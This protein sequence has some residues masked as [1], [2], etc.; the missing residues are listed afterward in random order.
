MAYLVPGDFCDLDVALL[1]EMDH[2]IGTLSPCEF[3]H[4]QPEVIQQLMHD[5]PAIG[6]AMRLAALVESAITREWVVNLGCRSAEERIAHLLLELLLRLQ[7]VGCAS[8]DSYAL[9]ITQPDIA[10]T[11]GLSLVHVSRTLK[12]LR[13][14][15]LINFAGRHVHILNFSQLQSVGEFRPNYLHLTKRAAE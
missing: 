14:Q 9:P 8:S 5:R 2:A 6:R 15:G 4:I 10:D 12:A 1:K 13:T 3:V 7:A 11:T